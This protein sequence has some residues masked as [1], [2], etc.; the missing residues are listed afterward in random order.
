MNK[1]SLQEYREKYQKTRNN[2]EDRECY[3]L[4][5]YLEELKEK[6]PNIKYTHIPHETYTTSWKVK[7]NNKKK[8]VKRGFPDYVIIIQNKLFFIE[9]KR[10]KG[11][12]VSKEQKEWI[13]MINKTKNNAYVCKGFEEAKKIINTYLKK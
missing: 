9:M 10:I 6:Y 4:V 3:D 7:L 13:I 11:G 5:L 8:G 1:I 12:V 2:E